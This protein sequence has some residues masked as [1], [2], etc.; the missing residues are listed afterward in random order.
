MEAKVC[1]RKMG[2]AQ[3]AKK[4]LMIR[5]EHRCQEFSNIHG[6]TQIRF[7]AGRLKEIFQDICHVLERESFIT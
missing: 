2:L 6:V 3:W 4:L 1:A 5:L 7:T